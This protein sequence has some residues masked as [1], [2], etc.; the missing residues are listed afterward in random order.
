[1]FSRLAMAR[2][3]STARYVG[4]AASGAS[5]SEDHGSGGSERIGSARLSDMGSHGEADVIGGEGSHSRSCFFFGPSIV[6]MS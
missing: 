2:V 1:L 4:G 5:G 3:K 6:T